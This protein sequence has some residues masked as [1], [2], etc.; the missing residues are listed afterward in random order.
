MSDQWEMSIFNDAELTE[1][2]E[3]FSGIIR[4]SDEGINLFFTFNKIQ[5]R[6]FVYHAHTARSL[7]RRYKKSEAFMSGFVDAIVEMVSDYLENEDE[8]NDGGESNLHG[9]NP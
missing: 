1:M 4:D 8:G 3:S 7:D 9:F 5:C 6:E 2:Q